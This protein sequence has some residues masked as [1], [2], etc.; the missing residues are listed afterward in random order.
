M[1]D[2]RGALTDTVVASPDPLANRPGFFEELREDWETN[3]R[4]WTAPGFRALFVNRFTTR[5]RAKT[6][7]RVGR[8][9][10]AVFYR[11]MNR[12]CRNIYGIQLS[13]TATIGRRLAIHHHMGVAVHPNAVIGDDCIL[14][15]GVTLGVLHTTEN[16][17]APIIGDRVDIG[18]GAR[19]LG[20]VKIGNDVVIGA[21]AVVVRD[22]PDGWAALGNPARIIPLRRPT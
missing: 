19:I 8:A 17:A 2:E 7:S 10:F 16:K 3:G 18:A 9:A 20:S 5:V 11:S 6:D 22:V 1:T 13:H 4:D 15:Q 21:N 12:F 14:R